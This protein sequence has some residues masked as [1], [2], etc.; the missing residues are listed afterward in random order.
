M[1][2]RV[3]RTIE[4]TYP[5]RHRALLDMSQWT[6]S[7]QTERRPDGEPAIPVQFVTTDITITDV[8]ELF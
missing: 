7:S 4:Y 3:V 2:I 8:P 1:T 5:N 6:H